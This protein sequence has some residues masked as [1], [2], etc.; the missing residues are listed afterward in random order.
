MPFA[1]SFLNYNIHLVLTLSSNLISS[2]MPILSKAA[3]LDSFHIQEVIK[4][5]DKNMTVVIFVKP[6]YKQFKQL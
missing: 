2:C 6:F 3:V 5:E 1:F 4:I